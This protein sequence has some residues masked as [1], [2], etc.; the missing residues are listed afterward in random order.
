MESEE[1]NNHNSC[2]MLSRSFPY[3][4][5]RKSIGQIDADPG[6]DPVVEMQQL[7]QIGTCREGVWPYTKANFAKTPTPAAYVDALN[8]RI[9]EYFA[10]ASLN[11]MLGCM[12]DGW[13]FICGISVYQSFEDATS[14]II[15]MPKTSEAFLGGHMIYVGGGYDR[16]KKMF[17]FLN[18]WG[19]GWGQDGFGW[20]P[21]DYLSDRNLA[22]D[23][24]TIRK[25]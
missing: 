12:A 17:K 18:S 9:K 23:F 24:F 6:T 4:N 16:H 22:S 2:T 21:F 1:I 25:V 5:Y 20:I 7:S 19:E 15:P 11:D 13:G 3:F 8:Y 14:G 10:L